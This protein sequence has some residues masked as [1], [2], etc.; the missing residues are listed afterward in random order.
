MRGKLGVVMALGAALLGTVGTR[1]SAQ[2]VRAGVYVAAPPVYVQ[3]VPV[4]PGPEYI[5]MPQYHRWVLPGWGYAFDRGRRFERYPVY[6]R[7]GPRF[8]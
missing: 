3:V 4:A 5:W 1:A 6:E 2:I 8:R 7:R